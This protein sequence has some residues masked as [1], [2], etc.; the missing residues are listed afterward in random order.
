VLKG[1]GNDAKNMDY[2]D[3]MVPGLLPDIMSNP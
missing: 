3:I 1:R 2:T